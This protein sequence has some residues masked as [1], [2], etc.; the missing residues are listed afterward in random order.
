MS[1]NAVGSSGTS[2][3]AYVNSLLSKTSTGAAS[4]ST[5][6]STATSS[7]ATSASA[8]AAAKAALDL[9]SHT[10]KSTS[11]QQKLDQKQ[12]ALGSDLRSAMAKAGVTLQG[13]IELSVGSGGNLKATGSEKD[14]AAAIAFLKADATKPS[15]ASRVASLASDA[16]ALST[17]LRQSAAISQAARSAG[18]GGNV[19][20]LYTSLLQQQEATPAV[21]GLSAS[22]SSL[23]YPGVLASKA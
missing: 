23:S 5:T 11:A 22:S 9:A 3:S 1:F 4:D 19:M 6:G 16:T 2:I 18:R 8:K 13:S 20:S 21:F 7:T 10:F 12:A 15:F 14:T 17:S